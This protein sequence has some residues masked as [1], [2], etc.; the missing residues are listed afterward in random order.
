VVV[1]VAQTLVLEMVVLAVVL[2]NLELLELVHQAK[3]MLAVLVDTLTF[4][5]E[6]AEVVLGLLVQIF[7]HHKLVLEAQDFAHLLQVSVFFMLEVVGVLHLAE[8]MVTVLVQQVVEMA[9]LLTIKLLQMDY[10]IQ[11]EAVAVE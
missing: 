4:L 1:E 8:L 3:E 2:V 7:L 5:L 11:G 6:V 9:L 10:L